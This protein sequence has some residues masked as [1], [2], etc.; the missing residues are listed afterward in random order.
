[1]TA[2]T[3]SPASSS[4]CMLLPR[5]EIR[6]TITRENSR[7]DHRLGLDPAVEV[8]R[9][10]VAEGER[11]LAQGSAFLVRLLRDLGG[12]VVA[13]VRGKRRD[14]HQ[15]ALE[16]LADARRVRLDAARAMLLE[17]A[18]AV[19]KQPSALQEGMDD[20]RLVDVELQVAGGA[21]D[22]DRYVVAEHLRG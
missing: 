21:A 4:A 5:P 18:A 12:A 1:M 17:R 11:G 6:M 2:D 22:I 19:G 15:R 9:L 10:H 14:Q 16:Q 20:H 8:F 7:S 13:D 3:G